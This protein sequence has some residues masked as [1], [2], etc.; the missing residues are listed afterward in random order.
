MRLALAK[1]LY[2]WI[3]HEASVCQTL[4]D[5]A[6]G[7]GFEDKLWAVVADDLAPDDLMAWEKFVYGK[8]Y[9]SAHD[10]EVAETKHDLTTDL[11]EYVIERPELS[12]M[13]GWRMHKALP[14]YL[15]EYHRRAF[16]KWAWSRWAHYWF[17]LKHQWRIL[18]YRLRK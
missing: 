10:L 8:R 7:D 18:R 9:S 14:P 16:P 3:E 13:P 11:N 17:E 6:W 4:G 15:R 1:K 12:A 5:K 2:A